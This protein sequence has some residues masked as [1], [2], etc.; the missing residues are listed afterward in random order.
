MNISFEPQAQQKLLA[1]ADQLANAVRVTLGPKGRNV[2]LYQKRNQ[3]GASYADRTGPGAPVLITND[4][5]TIAEAIVLSDPLEEAG[6]QMLREATSKTNQEAGDGTTTATVLA[7]NLLHEAFRQQAA[8]ADPIALR[9]GMMQAG[10]VASAALFSCAKIARDEVSL[11]QVAEISCGDSELGQLVGHALFAVGPEGVVTVEDAQKQETTLE[12]QEGIVLERGFLSP[13][14]ATNDDKT[15]AELFDP[16]ILLCDSKLDNIQDLLPAL[17]ASAEDGRDCLVI[18]E[19]LDGDARS[20]V[21]RTN[22]QGD[23]KIVCI[24]APLYGDGRRWRMEDLAIQLGGTYYQK[25]LAMNLR[26]VTLADLGTAR[27]VTVTKHRTVLTGPGGDPEK[28]QARIQELRFLISQESY[29]FNR[30]RHQERLARLSAGIAVI[31]VGG[32]TQAELWERKARLE[33]AVHAARAAQLDGIVPGGGTALLHL[34]PTVLDDAASL[35]G[36][37]RTGALIVAKSLEAPVRQI[38]ENAGADGSHIVSKLLSMAPEYGYDANRNCICLMAEQGIWDPVRVTRAALE[39][40]LSVA[41]TI[42]TTHAA[43]T[44]SVVPKKV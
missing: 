44:T 5:A 29:E 22:Q 40:A 37:E 34:I 16:C 42:L 35:C 28:L 32:K 15:I 39:N 27:H 10:N 20:T 11:S 21:L 13:D 43:V 12:I 9:R 18:C 30:R 8:G 31:H 24:E 41:S 1:G 2:A 17:I 36:D 7:Q 6:A 25:M 4:G 14:M 19:G 3:Q 23:I 26:A 38:A 33:D